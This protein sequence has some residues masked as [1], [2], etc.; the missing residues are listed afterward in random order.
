MCFTGKSEVVY[1]DST[2]GN[3]AGQWDHLVGLNHGGGRVA[4]G[5]ERSDQL[6]LITSIFVMSTESTFIVRSADSVQA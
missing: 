5:S 6:T 1:L 4:D 3:D 2:L